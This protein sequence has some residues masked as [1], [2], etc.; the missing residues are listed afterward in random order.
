MIP[1]EASWPT[2]PFPVK[3][4]PL[5]RLSITKDE[6]SKVTPESNKYCTELFNSLSGG[7]KIFTP[8]GPELSLAV[9]GTL[10]GAN[11]SGAS[12][13]PSLGYLYVNVNEVGAIGAMKAQ[14]DGT[15]VRYRRTSKWGEFAR[16]WDPNRYPCQQPPWGTFNAID[17]KTG[18]IAW[19]VTL[20]TVD[21]LT[22]RGVP[23]TG[24]PNIGGSVVTAGGLVFIAATNDRRFRAFD[25][26][27]GKEL[28]VTELPASGHATP[29]TYLGKKS[30][31]QYVVVAAGGGGFFSEE[32]SDTLVAYALPK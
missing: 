22:A 15:P 19:K 31:R 21:A 26:K 29:M 12:F 13:D 14:E 18:E 23:Q 9:P 28:W 20:G 17:L 24:T 1:G 2:Q 7:G 30:G 6:I 16:F 32:V 5:S 8:Y 11:W 3:P 27:T 25:A 4:A 10:G